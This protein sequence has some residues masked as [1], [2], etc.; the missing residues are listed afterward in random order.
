MNKLSWQH[1]D[2]W[3]LGTVAVLTI[4]GIT[5]IRSTITG[6][7]ELA[8]HANRQLIFAVIGFV[9]LFIVASIDYHVWSS[10]NK[11][12]YI[13]TVL[14]LAL[15]F[16]VGTAV[17]GSA[18]WFHTAIVSIQPSEFAKIV[19]ILVLAEFFARNKHRLGNLWWVG[20]SFLTTM[21]VVTWILIQPNLSTSIVILVIWFAMLWVSGLRTKHLVLFAGSAVLIAVLAF[22]F[23]EVYQQNRI[24]NFISPDQSARHGDIYNVQ[25]ALISIGSGGVLGQGYGQ[26][27]QV[28]LRFLKVRW[29]DFIFSA[30]AEELGFIG[31]VVIMLLLLFVIYRCLRAARMAKDT[32]G[33]LICYGVATLLAFQAMVNIG[34]NLNLM[35]AT[36]LPL[37]FISYGGSSLLSLLI[38]IGLVESVILRHKVLEFN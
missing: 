14:F 20:R 26:G 23:L 6:N 8:D 16:T 4:F 21:G 30:M 37:P 29:S 11:P 9:V 38:G 32:F 34:V 5:M 17:L 13:I 22:P 18:R 12:M 27:T 36:G 3:L 25:Q 28:Q 35:P 24:M 2:F 31:V 10:I 19:M 33:A 7:I 15:L 1:F